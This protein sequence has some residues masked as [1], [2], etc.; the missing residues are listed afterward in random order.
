MIV[1]LYHLKAKHGWLDKRFGELLELLR[2]MIPIDNTFLESLYAMNKMLNPLMLYF[3]TIHACINN[4][5]LYWKY[6]E[7][8]EVDLKYGESY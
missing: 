1:K 3:V 5:I 6:Y 2:D 4:Y 7:N 8:M